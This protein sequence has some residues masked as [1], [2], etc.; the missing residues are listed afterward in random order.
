MKEFM[1][2]INEYQAINLTQKGVS[3]TEEDF[4]KLY[5]TAKLEAEVFKESVAIGTV[6]GALIGAGT[7]GLTWL[8]VSQF[9]RFKKRKLKD[10]VKVEPKKLEK[11]KVTTIPTDY[12]K[13][14][15]KEVEISKEDSDKL[16]SIINKLERRRDRG[17]AK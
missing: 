8:G 6:R 13:D 15:D 16:D 7:V 4:T 17:N 12:V 14:D 3:F 9:K 2:K 1:D 10:E 5:D 11:S